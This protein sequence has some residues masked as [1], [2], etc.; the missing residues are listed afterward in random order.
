MERLLELFRRFNTR[1][2]ILL[3]GAI[4]VLVYIG[5]D[6]IVISPFFDSI[7]ETKWQLETK[8]KLLEKSYAFV[9][10][11]KR[12]ESRLHDLEK[13]YEKLKNKFLYEETE[14]LA[15]AKLQEM[16]NILAE[17]NGLVVSRSTALKKKVINKDPYLVAL[18]INFE[19]HNLD[20]TQKLQDFLL[21]IEYNKD[22]LFII[23]S[24]RLKVLGV[25]AV[26]EAV[27]NSTLTAVAFIG[28]KL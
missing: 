18:S 22:K 8:E 9:A 14:D 2:R 26:K 12:F 5:M 7:N 20:S 24:L 23:N 15:S 4:I 13:Y 10:N 28:E 21:D 19:I 17:K 6:R 25:K 11:K 3:I 1:E 16:I 27:L